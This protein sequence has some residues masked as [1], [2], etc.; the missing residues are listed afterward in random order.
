MGARSCRPDFLPAPIPRLAAIRLKNRS[1][2]LRAQRGVRQGVGGLLVEACQ[3]PCANGKT[4][5]FRIGFT[6][7]RKIGNAVAR[8]RAKRRLRA[9]AAAIL[10]VSAHQ[11]TDY[12][13]IARAGALTRSYA[14]LLKDLAAAVETAHLK[15][16]KT[17][18]G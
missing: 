18:D 17:K 6:A 12:V 14:L 1:D 9:A 7:S 16:S 11:H 3:T 8:N 4:G 10:P 2:F 13:I 5:A 15:L